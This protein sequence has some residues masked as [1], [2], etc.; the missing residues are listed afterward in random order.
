MRNH[1]TVDREKRDHKRIEIYGRSQGN[2]Y[3]EREK[4]TRQ[5]RDDLSQ[6]SMYIYRERQQGITDT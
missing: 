6:G 2:I 1:K 5:Y 3:I 4:V